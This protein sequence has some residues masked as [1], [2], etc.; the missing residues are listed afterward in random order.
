MVIIHIHLMYLR[1]TQIKKIDQRCLDPQNLADLLA[2]QPRPEEAFSHRQK[3]FII[4]CRKAFVRCF[5]LGL[6][7]TY[8]AEIHENQTPLARFPQ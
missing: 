2:L 4:S 3:V 1:S 7:G 6:P 5:Y 8:A